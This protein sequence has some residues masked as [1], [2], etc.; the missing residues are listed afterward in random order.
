GDK[1]RPADN[2]KTS[3]PTRRRAPTEPTDQTLQTLRNHRNAH[4][5]HSSGTHSVACSEY[6]SESVENKANQSREQGHER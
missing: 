2:S 1:I 3:Q 5:N 6:P 4:H